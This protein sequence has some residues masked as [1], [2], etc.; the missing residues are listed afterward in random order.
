[1]AGGSRGRS[2]RVPDAFVRARRNGRA[3]RQPPRG[4]RDPNHGT[5]RKEPL[6]GREPIDRGCCLAERQEL[7]HDRVYLVAGVDPGR[8]ALGRLVEPL[9]LSVPAPPRREAD[10]VAPGN[11][12]PDARAQYELDAITYKL[13]NRG[14]ELQP[15]AVDA[16][17][18]RAGF[19]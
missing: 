10:R 16:G 14:H 2:P 8:A 7:L 1:M 9:L 3:L 5:A 11:P 15:P 6:R 17:A 13:Y 18:L 4:G 19:G 12:D